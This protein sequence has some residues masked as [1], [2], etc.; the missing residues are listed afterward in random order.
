M[1]RFQWHLWSSVKL[2]RGCSYKHAFTTYFIIWTKVPSCKS[3]IFTFFSLI[4]LI[5]FCS[6]AMF[7]DHDANKACCCCWLAIFIPAWLPNLFQPHFLFFKWNLKFL[8]QKLS[9]TEYLQ[10]SF[11]LAISILCQNSNLKISYKLMPKQINSPS[12]PTAA[13]ITYFQHK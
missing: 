12:C 4:T 11:C 9:P 6:T 8:R 5:C 7:S 3:F 1:N 13:G 2:S 10:I